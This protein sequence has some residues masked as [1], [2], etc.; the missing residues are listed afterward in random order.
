MSEDARAM[1]HALL[2]ARTARSGERVAAVLHE[3]A[4]YWDPVNDDLRGREAVARALTAREARFEA[5][6][7][8]VDGADAV[9]EVQVTEGE[10][11]YRSTEV[12]ALHDGA[13]IAIRA[14]FDPFPGAG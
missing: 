2:D 10:R 7:V 13:V 12:Y 8:V 5:E 4:T 6:T 14:Y 1:L 3:D 11:R 9:L